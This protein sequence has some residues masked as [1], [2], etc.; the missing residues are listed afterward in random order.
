MPPSAIKG[1]S[2]VASATRHQ[3]LPLRHAEARRH[4]RSA[5]AARPYSDLDAVHVPLEQEPGAFRRAYVAG[6]QFDVAKSLAH[7]PDGPIHHDRVTVG[8]IDD[9]DVNARL[10]QLRRALEIVS[11]RANR[12]ADPQASLVIAGGER[13]PALSEEIAR[14][15]KADQP[16]ERQL[17]DLAFHHHTL[18]L[19]RRDRSLMDDQPIDR[20][21]PI[22][23]ACA[24]ARHES[25]VTLRQQAQ[26]T[27]LLVDDD[28]CADAGPGHHGGGFVDRRVRSNAVRVANDPVLRALDDLDLA[29]LGLN[30]AGPE[31]AIDH[32][33][34]ALLRLHDRHRRPRD[35]VHVR[36]HDRAL[37]RDVLRDAARQVDHRRIAPFQDAALRCEEEVVERAAAHDV[38]YVQCGAFVDARKLRT[39]H[40][41]DP[42][43]SST[44]Q[45]ELG[46]QFWPF[47]AASF[48]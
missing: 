5:T 44:D 12:S 7:F 27:P 15:D 39:G 3:R 40:T 46:R 13:Q 11:L 41:D 6:D 47:C 22:R 14:S 36:R 23:D 29:H 28:E 19:L 32:A 8:D 2:D 48:R 4:P 17:L 42:T 16:D 31:P 33:Q 30:V 34:A 35:S 18:G 9:E 10:D 25:K 24:G 26:Q 45:C 20:R 21:H 1:T 37:E 38:G 43:R